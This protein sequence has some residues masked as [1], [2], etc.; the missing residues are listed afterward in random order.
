MRNGLR[1]L[2]GALVLAV[3]VASAGCTG[4]G[5]GGGTGGSL[6]SGGEVGAGGSS[7]SGGTV[8]T[9][10]SP[11][12]GGQAGGG[13][14]GEGSVTT[15]SGTKELNALTPEEATQLCDDTYAYFASAIP[16]EI[17]CKW[18]ALAYAT[19]SSAPSEEKL[20]SNCTTKETTCL[21]GSA[22]TGN[23]GCGEIPPS[24]TATVA[25][26]S[27][28]ISEEVADF[29]KTVEGLPS[30]ADFTSEGTSAIWDVMG[31]S[32]P[33]NCTSLNDECPALYPPTLFVP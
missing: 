32:L 2:V 9:G 3:T 25:E 11:G 26:Y 4:N 5:G 8:G 28:C 1:G 15:L 13:A 6:G 19:S 21:A 16:R 7:S 29:I 12:S 31:A 17:S 20:R 24:C 22:P 18:K 23:P 33:P 27:A 10:G 14:S 30:C